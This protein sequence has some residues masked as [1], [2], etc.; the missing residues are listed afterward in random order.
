MTAFRPITL[1]VV[2]LVCSALLGACAPEPTPTPVP[3][4]ATA[5]P[6]ATLTATPLPTA[7]VTRTFTPAPTSTATLT[8]R[9][10]ATATQV[11]TR[12]PTPTKPPAGPTSTPTAPQLC[13]SLMTKLPAGIYVMYL[14]GTPE[15]IWDYTPRH[16]KVGVCNT[17]PPSSTP[18]G[19][20]KIA[21]TF[22]PGNSG[23]TQSA[24]THIEIKSG[25]NEITV[26][27]WVPGLQN[28][29][30]ACVTRE[31]A[32]TQVLYNDS[33]DPVFRALPWIDGKNRTTLQIKCGGDYA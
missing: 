3:P 15:L 33:P 7:T 16:F 20:Y 31:F 29:R 10:L 9:P 1:L 6:T 17:I 28:H 13:A 24:P 5:T 4:T 25:F 14:Y 21:M 2:A 27:P 26:G 19:K 30:A 18:A 11:R 23:A 22:P 12:T 32:D 8:P